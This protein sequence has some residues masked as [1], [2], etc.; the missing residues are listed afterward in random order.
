MKVK[1]AHF[2]AKVFENKLQHLSHLDF[3][4]FVELNENFYKNRKEIID[5]NWKLALDYVNFEQR[6]VDTIT[7]IFKHN[8]M[9]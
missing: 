4:L 7:E 1:V 6:L 9:I 3:S 5:K 8:K 2:D